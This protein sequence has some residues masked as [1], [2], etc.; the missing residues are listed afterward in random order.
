MEEWPIVHHKHYKI[1]RRCWECGA[2]TRDRYDVITP[3]HDHI[4]LC[5][6]CASVYK[7]IDKS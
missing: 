3:L 1:H 4:N 6:E 5:R 7:S 2:K